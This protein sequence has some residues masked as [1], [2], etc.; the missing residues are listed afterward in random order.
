MSFVK[1]LCRTIVAS[2]LLF[3]SAA[4][5]HAGI[6]TATYDAVNGIVCK[7]MWLKSR[8]SLDVTEFEQ[9]L[10]FISNYSK[11]RTA[12]IYGTGENAKAI[13]C[14]SKPIMNADGTATVETAHII[15][16]D[17]ATGEYEKEVKL[18]CNGADI[19][20][21][22]CAA[23]IGVDD[24]GNLYFGGYT[25]DIL[26]TPL[27][28]YH[29]KDIDNGTVELAGE[30]SI[31]AEEVETLNLTT[32]QSIYY[33]DI[34]GD[35]TGQQSH[36]IAMAAPNNSTKVCRWKLDQ[37]MSDWYGDF[38]GYVTWDDSNLVT[39][40]ADQPEWGHAAM[41]HILTSESDGGLDG[42]CFYVDGQITYPVI[43]GIDGVMRD[44][45][46]NA[47]AELTPRTDTNGVTEFSVGGKKFIAY[48]LAQYQ[49][50][51]GCQIRVAEFGEGFSFDGMQSYWELP[52]DGLGTTSDRGTLIHSLS[53][54]KITDENGL[55]GVYLLNYKCNNGI[56]LYL[57]AQ[58]GFI[59]PYTGEAV[60]A[61]ESTTP[62]VPSTYSIA[63]STHSA[64]IIQGE[65]MQLSATVSPEG[66]AVTYISLDEAVATVSESGLITAVAEGQTSIIAALSD[67]TA[68]ADTC[69]VTVLPAAEV[70]PSIPSK[71]KIIVD[72]VHY[73]ITDTENKTVE[74]TY[75]TQYNCT[76]SGDF[77]IPET[78]SYNNETYTVTGIGD[79][80]FNAATYI[81]T[82]TIPNTVTY[83]GRYAFAYSA[84]NSI[85]IPAS[86]TS[87][88][89]GAF[90]CDMESIV[91]ED[92]NSIYDSRDNCNAIIVTS[93]N[94]L[95][96][97]SSN[98]IIPNTVT[99]IGTHSFFQHY[100]L[101]SITIPSSVEKI[102]WL[103]FM[104]TRLTTIIVEATIPPVFEDLSF[105][106]FDATVYVPADCVETYKA[107]NYWSQFCKIV[108]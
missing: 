85:I 74:I 97:G 52:A 91:I 99:T 71:I 63:L 11:V 107:D 69:D 51:P 95:I 61:P 104:S 1:R 21:L 67:D 14:Y 93:T 17:L 30:L 65:S 79:D 4:T 98:T 5:M 81:T 55:E 46:M 25:A 88:D 84:L 37:G 31:P 18:S 80:A 64:S 6:D 90:A 12:T 72:G 38:D 47:P 101:T 50:D 36:V 27:K 7:N 28:I 20:G 108:E 54:M 86:V 34:C 62:E 59:D 56:G 10:P 76:Y 26:T 68:V 44:G 16:F 82:V 105:G 39:Y 9:Q 42:V 15:I 40:P 24:F 77:T 53:T 23:Q 78:I 35:I 102:E 48:S 89:T 58:N 106:T 13:L 103:A 45:F 8:S 92:G 43:Y 49:V 94:T 32:T 75:D 22:L 57:I 29:I 66:S 87:I 3:L 70:S 83:I 96:A 19:T 60:T 2:A 100:K 73:N 41:V 33:F